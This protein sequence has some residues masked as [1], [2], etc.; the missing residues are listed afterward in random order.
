M[1]QA[2]TSRDMLELKT[3]PH[4]LRDLVHQLK[5]LIHE[6]GVTGGQRIGDAWVKAVRAHLEALHERLL[7]QFQEEAQRGLPPAL[8]AGVPHL[9]DRVAGLRREHERILL[10][11][12]TLVEATDN[13]L[14]QGPPAYSRLQKG[15]IEALQD[16]VRC[17]DIE[18]DNPLFV[19]S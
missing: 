6:P 8:I 11:I 17:E 10:E 3:Q 13:V 12:R 18:M 2:A 16:L 15:T 1:T 7:A 5:S 4:E 9:A 14:V 19:Y